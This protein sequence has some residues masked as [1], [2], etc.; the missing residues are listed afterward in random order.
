MRSD[1]KKVVT[2]RP[3]ARGG[4]KSPK[5]T[6]RDF[7]RIGIEDSPKREKIR[8]KWKRGYES[9]AKQF[10]DVLG[11][12]YRYLLKQVGRP[13]DKVYSEIAKELPKDTMQNIHIYTHVW[14]FV[15]RD[16]QIING[17][18]CHKGSFAD[19]LPIVSDGKYEQLYIN[20]KTK[21]LCKAKKGR[22]HTR[23]F[24][25]PYPKVEPGV[26]AYPGFQY[27]K[28]Y[29]IWYGVKVREYP[30]ARDAVGNV[31]DFGSIHDN[32]LDCYHHSLEDLK[33]V[34]HGLWIAESKYRLT[35]KEIRAACLKV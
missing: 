15:E 21:L 11:P 16:V 28:R 1:M 32:V 6:N 25:D 8:Q 22:R 13:W 26:V 19:G 7:Q 17:K 9:N 10:T 30:L 3:R 27:H 14:Q 31:L 18:P 12:L 29:G 5:G 2:E 35:K 33:K 34:Y 23:Y 24:V 20:P 4:I